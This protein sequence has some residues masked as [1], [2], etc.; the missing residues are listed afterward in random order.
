[1]NIPNH[2]VLF[3]DGNRRWAKQKGM[4]SL[5]GHLA[6]E[7][8]FDDFLRWCKNKG[9]KII[10]VFGFSTE[11]WNRA[12][13]EV[14]YLMKLLEKY[15]G[16]GIDSFNKE[17]VKVKIIGQKEK[18]PES[19][20]KVIE[21]VEDST[22]NNNEFHLNLAV[23]YGGKWDILNAVKNILKE[24][25]A[26]EKIDEGLIDDYLSTAGLANPDLII[27]AGGEM[28]LSNFVLWQAA[29]SE[30]YFSQ[31]LWPDFTEQDLDAAIDEFDRRQRRFGK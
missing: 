20:K 16:Q 2:I 7:K 9:V 15:L 18:L 4:A 21:K 8:K 24:G 22:K 31:K 5:D 25:I 26:P 28:R 1:M 14:D 19:L 10:T 17:G 11:N 12:P 23:S 13:E 3:P 27:R 30:L 29:Y 6:G